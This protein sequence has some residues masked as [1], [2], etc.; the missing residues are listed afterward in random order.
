MIRLPR[1]TQFTY[2]I[3][4]VAVRKG[5]CQYQLDDTAIVLFKYSNISHS[6]SVALQLESNLYQLSVEGDKDTPLYAYVMADII[7]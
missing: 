4:H 5:I 7:K 3:K 1:N 6:Y 2:G